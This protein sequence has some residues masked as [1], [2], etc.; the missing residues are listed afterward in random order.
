M[1]QNTTVGPT[2]VTKIIT[3]APQERLRHIPDRFVEKLQELWN[4][5]MLDWPHWFDEDDSLY[6]LCM[7]KVYK[8]HVHIG[9]ASIDAIENMW[10][11]DPKYEDLEEYKAYVEVMLGLSLSFMYGKIEYIGA[12]HYKVKLD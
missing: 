5:V 8:W 3:N 7:Q 10:I 12:K 11:L 6:R 1:V 2:T 9:K 4:H